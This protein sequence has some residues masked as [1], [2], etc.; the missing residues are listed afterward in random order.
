MRTDKRNVTL[1]TKM[2]RN[3]QQ[4]KNPSGKLPYP[5]S[6]G[7]D[8]YDINTEGTFYNPYEQYTVD[9]FIVGGGGGGGNDRG[10]GGGGGQVIEVNDYPLW[11]G[12]K[13]IP[14]VGKGGQGG[15]HSSDIEFGA[16]ALQGDS[17]EFR[18]ADSG[19]GGEPF[20]LFLAQGGK[21]GGRRDQNGFG[22]LD[23]FAGGG[24]SGSGNTSLISNRA[25]GEARISGTGGR[26]TANTGGGGGGFLQDG[27]SGFNAAGDRQGGNGGR[28]ICPTYL[29]NAFPRFHKAINPFLET[30]TVTYGNG[31]GGGAKS[32]KFHSIGGDGA[33][34]FGLSGN[35][36]GT[37]A[38]DNTGS[39]GGGAG[40]DRNGGDG[41]AGI[42][43]VRFQRLEDNPRVE[44][45]IVLAD[46][47]TDEPL[48]RSINY[49]KN[50]PAMAYMP[51][52]S[53]IMRVTRID[54]E[55]DTED[56]N[57]VSF[58]VIKKNKFGDTDPIVPTI[59]L[60]RP[61]CTKTEN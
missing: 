3:K 60:G 17:S 39:G 45:E 27:K 15:V 24:G 10:G 46:K 55:G 34:G 52:G 44:Y 42:I 40:R 49:P 4:V 14:L 41:S 31:G 59:T 13:Y 61:T 36:N 50:Y 37:P 5:S 26:G 21:Q 20:Q 32:A 6:N 16:P 47:D 29:F 48:H 38:V 25:G 23:N 28:G 11:Y 12:E 8:T 33:G 57:E 56:K 2:A 7:V 19:N 35:Q 30:I 58:R 9:L 43:Y 51:D 53:V 54:N 18:Q 1:K 22:G